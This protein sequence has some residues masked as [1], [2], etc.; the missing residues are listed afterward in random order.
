[1]D[2]GNFVKYL[3]HIY[4]MGLCGG[5]FIGSCIVAVKWLFNAINKMIK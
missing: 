2:V 1:M 5:V 4:F 3:L